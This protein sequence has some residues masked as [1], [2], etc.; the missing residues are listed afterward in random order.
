MNEP[1][2][3]RTCKMEVLGDRSFCCWIRR[4]RIRKGSRR[5][6]KK[7][8]RKEKGNERDKKGNF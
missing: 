3:N 1:K 8:K 7:R 5:K 2:D 4:K 6:G